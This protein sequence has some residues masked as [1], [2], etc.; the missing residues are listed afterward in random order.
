MFNVLSWSRTH[1]LT[2]GML[3]TVTLFFEVEEAEELL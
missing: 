1:L 3:T 2:V